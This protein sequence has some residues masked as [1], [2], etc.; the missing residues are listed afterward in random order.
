MNSG[1]PD[2]ALELLKP[3]HQSPGDYHGEICKLLSLSCYLQ[4]NIESC[5]RYGR[6]AL[7]SVHESFPAHDAGLAWHIIFERMR[8]ILQLRYSGPPGSCRHRGW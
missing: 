4:G 8:V 3:L 7:A 2:K 1:N 6:E 5:T